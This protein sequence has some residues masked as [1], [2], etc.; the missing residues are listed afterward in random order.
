MAHG[1]AIVHPDRVEDE[2]DAAGLPDQ[3]LDEH[4]DLVQVGV[5]RDAIRVGIDDG[6]EW[7]VPIRLRFNGT[8]GPQQR[9]VRRPFK[10]LFDD[11]RTHNFILK[12]PWPVKTRGN[13]LTAACP[14][15]TR[16]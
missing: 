2:G 1:D 6:D 10:T 7:L 16:A 5:S 8:R 3:T 14:L 11:I 13:R 12:R 4:A 9:A 15:V